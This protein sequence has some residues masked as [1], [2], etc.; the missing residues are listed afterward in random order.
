MHPTSDMRHAGRLAHFGLLTL[1]TAGVTVMALPQPAV[2]GPGLSWMAAPS[3][4]GMSDVTRSI[5]S[6]WLIAGRRGMNRVIVT[7]KG[8][9][10]GPASASRIA[11]AQGRILSALRGSRYEVIHR[12]GALPQLALSVDNAGLRR[13]R[14]HPEVLSVER[15]GISRTAPAPAL[16]E[17]PRADG[18]F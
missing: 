7:I 5:F 10:G 6:P 11:L 16:R 4:A 14:R 17:A 1:L 13:L 9:P 3:E 2:A 8:I 12:Y 15:D 18:T